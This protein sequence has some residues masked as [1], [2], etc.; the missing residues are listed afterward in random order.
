MLFQKDKLKLKIIYVVITL[1]IGCIIPET[2][3]SQTA[4]S[5]SENSLDL[6]PEVI[7]N[8]PVLQ[9]WIKEVP[10]VLEDINHDPSFRTRVGIGYAEFPSTEHDGGLTISVDDIFIGRTGLTISG[11]YETSFGERDA[12]GV[13]L[14][15]YLL[16]LGY[17][18]NVA[19][20]VGY[21]AISTNNYSEDG[22]NI[23][24]KIIFPLSRSGAADLSVSHTFISPGDDDEVGITNVSFGYA[25]TKQ[26][27]LATEIEKQNSRVKK[28]SQFSLM[29]EWM[30]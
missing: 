10:N 30:P 28:D 1:A 21:R 13:N 17:Y 19:P 18:I 4:D 20:V 2:V 29:L 26:I 9:K 5:S 8:S 22:V 6:P 25:I 23:G 7:N 12:G 11:D 24:G 14:Q 27:R 3:Y 15:Y 16:P